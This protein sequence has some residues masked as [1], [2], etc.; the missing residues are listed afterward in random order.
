MNKFAL[1]I[2][3]LLLITSAKIAFA[4]H[5]EADDAVQDEN[6]HQMTTEDLSIAYLDANKD[7][8]ITQQEYLDGDSQND[9]KKFKHMD[10]NGD[11][12]L[13]LSEQR[14][15]EAVYQELHEQ[16]KAKTKS[17]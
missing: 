6:G 3:V 16:Y 15:I 9:A 8:V 1:W 10:A 7:G 4:N 2:S 5:H 14:E 17:I 12:L 13:D 11:G